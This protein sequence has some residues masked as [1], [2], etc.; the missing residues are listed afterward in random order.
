MAHSTLVSTGQLAAHLTDWAVVDCRWD[1]QDAAWGPAAYRAGHVPGAVH[2]ALDADLAGPK[3]GVGGRH[4]IPSVEALEALFGRLG[5]GRGTQVAVY[6]QDI[7]MF[8]G[9]LWWMLRYLGH[10]EVA[11]VDGGWAK[12]AREGRPAR[13]G[14]EHRPAATFDAAVR[15]DMRAGIDEVSQRAGD[16]GWLIVDARSP[17]RFEGHVEPIDRAAGHIPGAVNHPFRTNAS[18]DGTLL[19]ADVLRDRFATLLGGRDP[20]RVVMYCGSGVTACHNL[21]AMAHAGLPGARLFPGSWSE[22]SI[23]PA[24]PVETGLARSR[25]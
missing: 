23:D 19:P 4:P 11:L 13:T 18:E 21:L 14:D 24:R 1:L 5:I 9:R 8:A 7:G 12:W 20:E 10:E 2:A 6:D 16:P 3:T 22:W 17:E 15:P 25:R